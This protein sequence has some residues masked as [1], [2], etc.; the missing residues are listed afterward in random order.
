MRRQNV[1]IRLQK[2][3]CSPVAFHNR[4]RLTA[5]KV[6][7]HAQSERVFVKRIYNLDLLNQNTR[8]FGPLVSQ[9]FLG[10]CLEPREVSRRPSD[11]LTGQPLVELRAYVV[12][13]FKRVLPRASGFDG[14]FHQTVPRNPDMLPVAPDDFS[15]S[16]DCEPELQQGLPQA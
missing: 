13:I 15:W 14:I 3:C 5:L 11:P 9:Q 8:F 4:C 16:V 2:R 6:R 7:L 10:F 1:E 12:E